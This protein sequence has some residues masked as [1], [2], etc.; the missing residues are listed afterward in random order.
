MFTNLS[1]YFDIPT[2]RHANRVISAH[3]ATAGLPRSRDLAFGKMPV[4]CCRTDA[5]GRTFRQQP[6]HRAGLKSASRPPAT[7]TETRSSRPSR[8][9]SVADT[10]ECSRLHPPTLSHTRPAVCIPPVPSSHRPGCFRASR[11]S[12]VVTTDSALR[13]DTVPGTSSATTTASCRRHILSSGIPRHRCPPID[14]SD[15]PPP[16]PA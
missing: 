13:P 11:A 1:I 9:G 10:R 2:D 12:P 6:R 16:G 7:E 15:R 4:R 14:W 8:R 3:R 5:A